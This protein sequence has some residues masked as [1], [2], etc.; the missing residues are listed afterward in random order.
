[1]GSRKHPD[2]AEA[3]RRFRPDIEGLRA[4]AIVAVLLCHA[5]VPFLAGG[6]IGGDG[7]FV[8][9]GYLITRV[10]PG[11]R[12]VLRL[13]RLPAPGCAGGGARPQRPNHPARFLRPP[14]QTPA[15]ALGGPA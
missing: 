3:G 14:R 10:L 13:P 6:Y 1:M 7:F 9:S 4:V 12:L 11:G 8:I 2:E 5:G 15:A